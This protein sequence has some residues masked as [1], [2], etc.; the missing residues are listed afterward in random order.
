MADWTRLTRELGAWSAS[1]KTATFWW[2]DDDAG[3]DESRLQQ[4]LW[5]RRSL[6]VP[7]AL[8]VVPDWLDPVVAQVI[9]KEN[10]VRALQHGISHA[11]RTGGSRRK[12]ELAGEAP[13]SGLRQALIR[14]REALCLLLGPS[15]IDV[16]VPPWNRIDDNVLPMLPGCGFFGLSTFGPR[17]QSHS[18]GLLVNNV[19]ID[20]IDWRAGRRFAGEDACLEAAVRHLE[21]RRLG[22][23]DPAE[24]TGLMTHHLVHDRHCRS[25]IDR[26][27]GVV[28]DHPA[29]CWLSAEEVF[30][31]A[32]GVES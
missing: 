20:I 32:P 6:D 8:A 18:G 26:F 9:C 31:D 10:D 13:A 15:L 11:D 12:T 14:S 21:R 23:A 19:H 4:L 24:A 27:V 29:T 3:S 16:M 17:R 1:G 30:R 5:Q 28:R 25:F 7:L 2:R 22:A